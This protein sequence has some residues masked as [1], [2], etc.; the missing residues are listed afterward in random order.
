MASSKLK[1]EDVE[2]LLETLNRQIRDE[3]SAFYDV[4]EGFLYFNWTS[5]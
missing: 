3:S 5:N 1:Y 4:R 2:E